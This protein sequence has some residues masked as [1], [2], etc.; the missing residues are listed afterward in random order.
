MI[1]IA[2]L[3]FENSH[4]WLFASYLAPK[5]GKK[6]FEDVE[7]L[8]IYGDPN[9]DGFDEAKKQIGNFSD[10]KIYTD[11]Y[12]RF[13]DEADAIM[14]TARHGNNH[15]KY[16]RKYVEKGIPVWIDKPITCSIDEVVELVELAKKHKCVLSGGSS[17]EHHDGVK[18]MANKVINSEKDIIGGHVSAPVNMVNPYGDFWFYTQHLVGIM[19]TIFGIDVKSVKAFEEP[20][21]VHAVYDYGKFTVSAHYGGGYTATV[22]TDAFS[23]IT[24]TFVLGED[25]Y[26]PEVD[27]FYEV[28]K[29]GKP[30]KTTKE[31]IA[32]VY[33]I[34]ATIKAYKEN[35]EIVIDIPDMQ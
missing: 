7:L 32:P 17:L 25:F 14:V 29:T 28:I 1:K 2:I 13:L 31:Y 3:G 22:Y 15:L 9:E 23:A 18:A 20:N 16:A 30:D 6:N 34:D 4:S 27:V 19:T 12:N 26:K 35:K 21:G 33:I 24:D 11:D 5:D 10:C 8:G